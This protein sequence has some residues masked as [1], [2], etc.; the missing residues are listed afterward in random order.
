MVGVEI[1][2][3]V[4]IVGD[5]VGGLAAAA[6]LVPFGVV[7]VNVIIEEKVVGGPVVVSAVVVEVNVVVDVEVVG[8]VMVGRVTTSSFVVLSGSIAAARLKIV[9]VFVVESGHAVVG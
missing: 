7:G 2:V 6:H 8:V 9:F 1:G 3:G 5:G 4:D